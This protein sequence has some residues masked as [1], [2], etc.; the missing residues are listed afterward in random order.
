[1][2]YNQHQWLSIKM[3]LELIRLL[4]LAY[5]PWVFT[6][7]GANVPPSKTQRDENS[8]RKEA[9][10]DL[11]TSNTFSVYVNIYTQQ[12]LNLSKVWVN[13]F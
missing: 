2:P 11:I 13:C 7:H 8:K 3:N 4:H 1:M 12:L 5:Q 9:F 10:T 6:N